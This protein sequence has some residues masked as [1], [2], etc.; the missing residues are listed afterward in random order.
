MPITLEFN[1]V[2][3]PEIITAMTPPAPSET[4]WIESAAEQ[5]VPVP[6]V[7]IQTQPSVDNQLG[8]S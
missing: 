2:T 5:L 3:D 4:E 1:R 7:E 6:V 8:G